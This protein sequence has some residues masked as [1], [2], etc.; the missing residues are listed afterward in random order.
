MKKLKVDS[1]S[2]KEV[3]VNEK[4]KKE[5]SIDEFGGRKKKNIIARHKF[6]FLLC[7]LAFIVCVML[8]YI[9]FSLFIGGNDPYGDRLKGINSVKISSKLKNEVHES[10]DAIENVSSSSVRVQGKIIYIHINV[11]ENVGLDRAKEIANESLGKFSDEQKKY[12]DF[13][14]FL[15][16]ERENGFIVTGTKNAN[17]D[18]IVWLKS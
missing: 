5:N 4:R 14:F 7:L 15:K 10:L 3:K 8:F 6:L 1:K 9:F 13:G 2:K 11:K 18:K 16:Q 12:Y 17:S